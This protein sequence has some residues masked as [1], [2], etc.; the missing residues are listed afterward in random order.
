MRTGAPARPTVSRKD[1]VRSASC[2]GFSTLRLKRINP[3]GCASRKKRRS[4][5]SR[6]G[7]AHPQTKAETGIAVSCVDQCGVSSCSVLGDEAFAALRLDFSAQR[8]CLFTREAADADAVDRLL[9]DLGL[10]DRRPMPVQNRGELLSKTSCHAACVLLV[11]WCGELHGEATAA[12][13]AL[14][15]GRIRRAVLFGRGD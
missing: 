13:G 11:A 9:A 5:M 14:G 1:A 7:P 10:H 6:L 15:R 4:H 12:A 2:A 8:G 3:Q